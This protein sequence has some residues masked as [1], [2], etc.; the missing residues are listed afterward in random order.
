MFAVYERVLARVRCS[1]GTS[2]SLASNIGAKQGC[3]LSPTLFE[4]NIY[5]LLEH[6]VRDGGKS[7]DLAG[8]RCAWRRKLV[9]FK[10]TRWNRAALYIQRVYRGHVGRARFLAKQLEAAKQSRILFFN[11]K[12]SLI[13]RIFRGFYSR[14]YVHS[15]YDRKLFIATS[16]GVGQEVTRDVQAYNL[17]LRHEEQEKTIDVVRGG[18]RKF[19]LT[20]HHLIS[21]KS[22]NGVF[23]SPYIAVLKGINDIEDRIIDTSK[24]EVR[25][26]ATK[27][28]ALTRRPRRRRKGSLSWVVDV[29]S[30]IT[31][32][33]PWGPT[34]YER[35]RAEEKGAKLLEVGEQRFR[36]VVKRR[37]NAWDVIEGGS[38]VRMQSEWRRKET[39]RSLEQRKSQM[40]YLRVAP[41]PFFI[42]PPKQR[43][44][45]CGPVLPLGS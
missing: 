27:A 2:P 32:E 7:V 10:L 13:Q 17:D 8:T 44:F 28:R 29:S 40:L 30:F 21:T 34:P 4:L 14:K 5:V 22:R 24:E 39:L 20:N 12:A 26:K 6:I 15:F 35:R 42:T 43:R 31:T 41:K 3:P 18:I 11:R 33:G 36:N 23:Y 9:A 37:W 25:E 19:W 1:G 38:T 45:S 16:L